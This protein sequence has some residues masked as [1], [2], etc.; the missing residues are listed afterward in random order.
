MTKIILVFYRTV[1]TEELGNIHKKDRSLLWYVCRFNKSVTY[2]LKG[3][4]L[5]MWVVRCDKHG[6]K[7]YVFYG[8][9][10]YE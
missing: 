1:I 2:M 9:S 8:C 10:L 5:T 3:K 6:K 7:A 4:L